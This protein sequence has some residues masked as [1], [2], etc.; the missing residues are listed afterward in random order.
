MKK[1]TM[2]AIVAIF[3]LAGLFSCPPQSCAATINLKFA[4]YFPPVAPQS[5]LWNDFCEEVQKRTNGAVKI[6]FYPGGSL[7]DAMAMADAV[8]EGIVDIGYTG[9]GFN[10]GRYPVSEAT[11]LSGGYPNGYVS[12]HVGWDFYSKLKPKEWDKCH[13]LSVGGTGPMCIWSTKPIRNLGDISGQKLRAAGPY[14]EI[15]GC[16]VVPRPVRQPGSFMMP[17]QKACSLGPSCRLKSVKLGGWQKYANMLLSRGRFSR[18][19]IF[20]CQ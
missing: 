15:A 18:R 9:V 5:K 3:G 6:F 7:I 17:Y 16:L 20:M 1:L 11:V 14:A 19:A 13:I 4:T 8:E 10:P 2:V 12:S